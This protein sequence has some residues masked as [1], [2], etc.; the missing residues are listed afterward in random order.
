MDEACVFVVDDDEAVRDSMQVLL[1]LAGLEVKAYPSAE[2]FLDDFRPAPK[3]CLVSDVR[4]PGKDGL[5]LQAELVARGSSLPIVFITGHGDIP[6]AVRAMK[7]GAVDF[8]EKPFTDETILGSI[9]R[10]LVIAGKVPDAHSPEAA[11]LIATLTPREHDVLDLLVV[12]HPNK[13]I[14]HILGISPRTV[15]I[16]RARV[17]DKMKAPSLSQLVRT[18]LAAGVDPGP[19]K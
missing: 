12:G 19:F 14:A 3:T 10:A 1:E 17:M 11:E 15:E 4:M 9:R 7:A 13:V 8:V 6:M 16:H 5:A 2:A 18:A